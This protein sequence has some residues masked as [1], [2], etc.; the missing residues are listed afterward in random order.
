MEVSPLVID[1]GSATTKAGVAGDDQPRAVFPSIVGRPRTSGAIPLL[2]Q[3]DTYVGDE[4]QS[5]RSTLDVKTPIQQRIVTNWDDMEKLWQHTF[6]N[7]LGAAPAEHPVLLT[8]GPINPK[9]NREKMTQIMFETFNTPSFYVSTQALLSVFASGRVTGT[10]VDSG[11]DVTHIVPIYE[12]HTLPYAIHRLDFAGHEL[13]EYLRKMLTERGHPFTTTAEREMVCDMKEKLCYVASDF[14]RELVTSAS[15]SSAVEK[16]YELPDR[17]EITLIEER[18]RCPEALFLPSFLGIDSPSIHEAVYNSIMKCD[19]DLWHSLYYHV[20][21]SGGN[22]MFP[23]I[24]DR[25]TRELATSAPLCIDMRVKVFAPPERK[26]AAWIGGSIL[27]SL[28]T[29]EERC[30]S[31]EEY[32]EDGAQIVHRKCF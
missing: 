1:N 14:E 11:H 5:R 27:A 2:G 18:F 30:I 4:A 8:E 16:V 32:N 12:G 13:T 10:V 28:S 20:V 22:T 25:L 31:S 26:Y 3:K 9:D 21:L 17:Q 7:E 29:F 23:G 19:S 6:Y 15:S 24:T